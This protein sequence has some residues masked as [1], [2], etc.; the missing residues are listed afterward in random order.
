MA[1][2]TPEQ[3][4]AEE[5]AAA[6]KAAEQAAAEE[7]EAAEKLAKKYSKK[8]RVL[9]DVTVR[10]KSYTANDVGLFS[11]EEIKAYDGVLDA[12]PAAVKYAESLKAE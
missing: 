9:V 8:A 7:A 5:A 12:H 10:E 6:A 3:I 1:N 4:A 11:D 2:K